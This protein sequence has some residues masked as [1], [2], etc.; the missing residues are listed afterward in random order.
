[1]HDLRGKIIWRLTSVYYPIPLPPI[2]LWHLSLLHMLVPICSAVMRSLPTHIQSHASDLCCTNVKQWKICRFKSSGR[3]IG[4][5]G[6]NWVIIT[7]SSLR[8]FFFPPPAVQ[9]H[10]DRG[11]KVVVGQWYRAHEEPN[12]KYAEVQNLPTMFLC[13]FSWL[14][15]HVNL[16]IFNFRKYE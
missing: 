2:V 16:V 12:M 14:P 10:Q 7:T 5:P 3:W 15:L 1:M 8:T 6:P 4:F 13:V 11:K 9:L